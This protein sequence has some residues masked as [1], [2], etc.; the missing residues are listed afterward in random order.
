MQDDKLNVNFHLCIL[1][2]PCDTSWCSFILDLISEAAVGGRGAF[3]FRL[4]AWF[5]VRVIT[6]VLSKN[7][8]DENDKD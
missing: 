2:I 1:K 8:T 6:E 5:S 3:L 4:L 7:Q